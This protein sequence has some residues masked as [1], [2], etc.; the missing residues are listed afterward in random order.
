MAKKIIIGST[1]VVVPLKSDISQQIKDEAQLPSLVFTDQAELE[2]WILDGSTEKDGFLPS[3]LA[4]GQNL[5]TLPASEPDFWV[6]TTPVESMGD[7]EVLGSDAS[8]V[9]TTLPYTEKRKH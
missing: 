1:E 3:T 6:V 8:N 2:A 9:Q 5:Y 7:L 4:V